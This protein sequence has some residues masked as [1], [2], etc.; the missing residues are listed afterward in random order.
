MA[1]AVAAKEHLLKR[2]LRHALQGNGAPD[3]FVFIL[4][5]R[6]FLRKAFAKVPPK[7]RKCFIIAIAK[8]KPARAL[9]NKEEER[10][11]ETC[12]E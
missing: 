10:A 3:R 5:D 4:N 7:G 8:Q 12:R 1:R 6:V 11:K 9:R 2:D